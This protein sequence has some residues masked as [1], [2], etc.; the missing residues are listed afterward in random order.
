MRTAVRPPAGIRR[1]HPREHSVAQ[2]VC[3][4][5]AGGSAS[6][7]SSLSAVLSADIELLA[8]QY[9]GRQERRTAPCAR[10]VSALAE[11]AAGTLLQF[12]DQPLVLFGH[13]MG[14]L[15]AFETARLI[16]Q[17]GTVVRLFASAGRP[18]SVD[19]GIRDLD[20]CSD[21]ALIADLRRLGGMPEQLL[22]EEE[23][24][25]EILRVL[26]ADYHVLSSYRFLAGR[27]LSAPVTALL[28]DTDPK[29]NAGHAAG[30]AR[31]TSAGLT[32]TVLPGGHFYLNDQLAVLAA[33]LATSIYQDLGCTASRPPEGESGWDPALPT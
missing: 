25:Q 28:G 21:Q 13:S 5:H 15:I 12:A 27:V 16:E 24:R 1:F 11:E 31:H 2:L 18:P 20:E 3:F 6:A 10:G 4:P 23:V 7:F 22:E 32:V 29:N 14:A 30:W 9:P 26:R 17:H 8:V 19:W 33:L